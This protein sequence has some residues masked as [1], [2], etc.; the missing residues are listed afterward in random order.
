MDAGRAIERFTPLA[1]AEKIHD[2][3][4]WS[5]RG[6]EVRLGLIVDAVGSYESVLDVGSGVG[7][8]ARM[9]VDCDWRGPRYL[10]LDVTPAI[11]ERAHA[12]WRVAG[13]APGYRERVDFELSD[14]MRWDGDQFDV[15]AASGLFYLNTGGLP[16]MKAALAKMVA[17]AG[18]LVVFNTLIAS[19]EVPTAEGEFAPDL[20]DVVAIARHLCP[21]IVVRADYAPHDV[22]VLMYVD[23]PAR[24]WA[25]PST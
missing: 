6:Q 2:T 9:L 10:G 7:A 11:V 25:P 20:A 23:E 15:V 21:R 12:Q 3:A 17:H 5:R 24:P 16:A 19:P 18:R 1:T 13:D 8:L 4:D 22:T 14:W